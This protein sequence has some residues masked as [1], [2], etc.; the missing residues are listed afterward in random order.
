MLDR[1]KDASYDCAAALVL[2]APRTDP[3]IATLMPRLF[4]EKTVDEVLHS[5]VGLLVSFELSKI[6][7]NEAEFLEK[8]KSKKNVKNGFDREKTFIG[9]LS[10]TSDVVELMNAKLL[11]SEEMHELASDLNRESWIKFAAK[12]APRTT[13]W[14]G[15]SDGPL[16]RPLRKPGIAH[17]TP[18]GQIRLKSSS[19]NTYAYRW[20][21]ADV[22]NFKWKKN[23]SPKAK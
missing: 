19:K 4:P 2:Q 11:I 6:V 10:F 9:T 22:K 5:E 18:D 3:H 8:L 21:N 23:K 20:P 12:L 13:K 1:I 17:L 14:R 16:D 15:H 7:G